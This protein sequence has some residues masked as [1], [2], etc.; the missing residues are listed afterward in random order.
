MSMPEQ[1]GKIPTAQKASHQ[2]TSPSPQTPNRGLPPEISIAP[3]FPAPAALPHSAL[4][5]TFPTSAWFGCCL[6]AR[7]SAPLTAAAGCPFSL[8]RRHSLGPPSRRSCCLFIMSK[9]SST[10]GGSTT[11]ALSKGK[12]KGPP[13]PRPDWSRMQSTTRSRGRC[14]FAESNYSLGDWQVP[15]DFDYTKST[16]DNYTSPIPVNDVSRYQSVRA[17]RDHDY[18][19]A[20]TRERQ[21]F[22]GEF[23][24]EM[25]LAAPRLFRRVGSR[26]FRGV[27]RQR[28]PRGPV[29]FSSGKSWSEE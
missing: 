19:G 12:G 15:L 23:S 2:P 11:S 9:S 18:H 17:T 13:P 8:Y 16:C 14:S 4:H 1:T 22:Q 26:L 20:Y 29:F 10:Y 27:V 25:L 7:R 24:L 5:L 3:P 21:L 28:K 6:A